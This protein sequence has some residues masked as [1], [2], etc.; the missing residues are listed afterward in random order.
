LSEF[1][2]GAAAVF[3]GGAAGEIIVAGLTNEANGED[4]LVSGSSLEDRAGDE[5]TVELS[6][7]E[8]GDGPP[9]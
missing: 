6:A 3:D 7:A 1:A 9:F 5:V 2:D 4:G 8:L